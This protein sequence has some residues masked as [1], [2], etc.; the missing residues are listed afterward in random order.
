MV[1]RLP[2]AEET[3]MNIGDS[4]AQALGGAEQARDPAVPAQDLPSF[5]AVY[6]QYFPFV[7]SSALRLGTS[8][9]AIDDVVQEIFVVIHEKLATLRQPSSLRSWIYGIVRRTVSDHR[10]LQDTRMRSA[11]ALAVHV[12]L[13]RGTPQTPLELKLRSD[14]VKLLFSLLEE[15]PWPKR[16][17]FM[18]AELEEWTVPE[19]ADALDVPLNTVY[20]RLRAARLAFEELL[21]QRAKRDEGSV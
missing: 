14:Q 20:S 18:L 5:D 2:T 11:G 9:A 15:I 6:E 4:A 19:I 16:E 21:A 12:E 3:T 17:V 13:E 1:A 8:T 10:R 7:W